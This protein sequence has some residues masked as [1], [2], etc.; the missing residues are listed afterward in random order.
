MNWL[1]EVKQITEN[2]KIPVIIRKFQ[3]SWALEVIVRDNI[4]SSKHRNLINQLEQSVK[5]EFNNDYKN[6]YYSIED[7]IKNNN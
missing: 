1:Y 2:D 5:Q 3:A 6:I 4:P 7:L